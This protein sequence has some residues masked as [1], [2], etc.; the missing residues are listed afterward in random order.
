M[1]SISNQCSIVRENREFENINQNIRKEEKKRSSND[2]KLVEDCHDFEKLEQFEEGIKLL[3][4]L[5]PRDDVQK[6]LLYI[7]DYKAFVKCKPSQALYRAE[8]MI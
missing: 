2:E 4:N 5:E 7:L 6:C 3:I 8:C 1:Q